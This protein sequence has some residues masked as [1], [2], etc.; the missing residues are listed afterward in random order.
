MLGT[1]KINPPFG[2][3]TRVL[4]QMATFEMFEKHGI[5]QFLILFDCPWF[6]IELGISA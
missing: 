5:H 6:G 3:S 1:P 2:G 4:A